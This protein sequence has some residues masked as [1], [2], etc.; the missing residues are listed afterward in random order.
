MRG[1]H[2]SVFGLA[3]ALSGSVF[4]A[5][6]D[7]PDNIPQRKPGLWEMVQ[8]GTVGPNKLRSIKRYCLDAKA[9]R[10]LYELE[11][12]RNELTV[13]YSDIHCRP[14]RFTMEGNVL[15][16]DMICRTNSLTDH[17]DAGQDYHWKVVFDGD[18][19]V[20]FEQEATPVD[21]MLL[22]D[23]DLVENQKWVGECPAGMQPGDYID[24]GFHYNSDADPDE[25]RKDNIYESSRVVGKMLNEGKEINKRLGAM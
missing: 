19:R 12:L 22:L 1:V 9:D 7:L 3:M 10:A 25:G 24:E 14:P 23:V 15:T 16:G 4:A 8:T 2:A 21:V 5:N 17:Q 11:L 13:V 20:T 6:Y 18:T